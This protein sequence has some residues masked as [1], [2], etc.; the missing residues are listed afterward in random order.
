MRE[1]R[2]RCPLRRE[3]APLRRRGAQPTTHARIARAARMARA[4]LS[5]RRAPRVNVPNRIRG[6]LAGNELRG[7]LAP[8]VLVGSELLDHPA[9]GKVEADRRFA[10]GVAG[11]DD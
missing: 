6:R 11:Y 3:P 8:A 2:S 7:E 4:A 10:H 5:R 1:A 9:L